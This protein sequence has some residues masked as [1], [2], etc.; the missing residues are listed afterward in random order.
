LQ[1]FCGVVE[2]ANGTDRAIEIHL[3]IF[4]DINF[5]VDLLNEQEEPI[6][7]ATPISKLV[8]HKEMSL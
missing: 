3:A 5:A 4:I 2:I 1:Q 6:H 8:V 7:T